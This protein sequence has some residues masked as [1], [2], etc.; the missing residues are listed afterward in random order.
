VATPD[1]DFSTPA[2][3][4]DIDTVVV[5]DKSGYDEDFTEGSH[6][7]MMAYIVPGQRT[8][9]GY[10]EMHIIIPIRWKETDDS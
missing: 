6:P 2:E 5:V 1:E 8:A 4:I 10:S 7:G 3:M 9:S